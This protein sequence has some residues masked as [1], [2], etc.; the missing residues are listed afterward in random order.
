MNNLIGTISVMIV[1]SISVSSCAPSYVA[2][3]PGQPVYVRPAAPGSNY[4]WVNDNWV[5][6]RGRYQYVHGYWT[7]PRRNQV[8]VEGNWQTRRNRYYWTPGRWRSGNRR[9]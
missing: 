6:Q 1:F 9:Y 5:W 7:M 3:R 2:T 4:V 8:W